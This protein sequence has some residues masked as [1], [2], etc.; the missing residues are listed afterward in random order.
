[1]K[2]PQLRP[3]VAGLFILAGGCAVGPNYHPP[4]TAAPANWS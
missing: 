4:H 1:M 2:T 3:F